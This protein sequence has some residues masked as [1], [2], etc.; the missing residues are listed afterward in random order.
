M[1][2]YQTLFLVS[3]LLI[4]ASNVQAQTF[5]IG[6][7]RDDVIRV[8]GTP[9]AIFTAEF[10]GYEEFRYDFST[11][12]ISLKTKKVLEWSNISENLKVRLNPGSNTS[13]ANYY[14]I[15]SHRDDVLKIQGTPDAIFT[16]EFSGYEEFRYEFS[17][18]KISLRTKKVLEWS[19]ISKNLKVRLEP[20]D[21]NSTKERAQ[22]KEIPP[23]TSTVKVPDY[24]NRQSAPAGY[25]TEG[26]IRNEVLQIQGKPDYLG[27]F[28]DDGY[29]LLW[30][31]K[32]NIKI[33]LGSKRVIDW[34]NN[35]NNLKV[36]HSKET[37][38][39]SNNQIINKSVG[40][41]D[42]IDK[43]QKD[44][45]NKTIQ[46]KKMIKDLYYSE[47]PEKAQ[48][49][50]DDIYKNIIDTY[51]A[52]FELIIKNFYAKENPEKGKRLSDQMIDDIAQVYELGLNEKI[53]FPGN[54][55]SLF[56][57]IK[58]ANPE[59]EEYD[60]DVFKADMHQDE[61]L[62]TVF[63]KF[64]ANNPYLKEYGFY[65][66][67]TDILTEPIT[68]TK[69][70]RDPLTRNS[71]SSNETS[72]TRI[73]TLYENLLK[74]GRVTSQEIGDFQTFCTLTKDPENI[75]KLY[76]NLRNDKFFKIEEIGNEETFL[77]LISQSDKGISQS[78]PSF[79]RQEI[80]QSNI[81]VGQNM[82]ESNELI[83]TFKNNDKILGIPLNKVES[84]L[85]DM[86]NAEE[87]RAFK[88][89]EDKY[90]IPIIKVP[91]FLKDVPNAI[92][93]YN[94]PE[95]NIKLLS[96]ISDLRNLHHYLITEF[97]GF[98]VPFEQFQIDMQD[99]SKLKRLHNN[100]YA[101]DNL[102]VS[103]TEF[104]KSLFSQTANR[105]ETI[106]NENI[107]PQ[108]DISD[109][110]FLPEKIKIG[111]TE[112]ELPMPSFFVRVDN[113]YKEQLEFARLLVPKNA[114]LISYYLGDKDF[115]QLVASGYHNG[116]KYIL[117]E[118]TD[119]LKY[120][121]VE[122][123][124][125][126]R[127]LQSIK[128]DYNAKF[129]TII[130]KGAN[131]AAE[132]ISK[133]FNSDI[134]FK[135]IDAFPLGIYYES[136]NVL[137]TGTLSKLSYSSDGFDSNEKIVACVSSIVRVN[138]K[139][140]FLFLY[141]KYDNQEDLEWIKEINK[142]WM[143]EIE[144][145]QSPTNFFSEFDFSEFKELVFAILFLSF[146]GTSYFVTRRIYKR[147]KKAKPDMKAK[148]ESKDEFVDFNDLLIVENNSDTNEPGRNMPADNPDVSIDEI[149]Q[150]NIQQTSLLN[151]EPPGVEIDQ[152][153]SLKNEPTLSTEEIVVGNVIDTDKMTTTPKDFFKLKWVLYLIASITCFIIFMAYITVTV[154]LGFKHGGG[155]LPMVLLG[156][157]LVWVWK[158]IIGL[159]KNK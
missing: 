144:D 66:F 122:Q 141:K 42:L 70:K 5:T 34:N 155:V 61:H 67:K 14:T 13:G 77:S 21:N 129:D 83:R 127:L 56:Y 78:S 136:K 109:I 45:L 24:S 73:K 97:S 18:V 15:G 51:N 102:V 115:G 28:D 124:E 75:I 137:S 106:Q 39:N 148:T 120:K 147:T 125:F 84:F 54:L 158:K 55:K 49:L 6:S 101:N 10:S 105:I 108:K 133:Y 41:D 81:Y 62:R 114:T 50:T 58:S 35:E 134:D 44:K 92:A 80:L 53:I 22:K 150:V 128:K 33:S 17:T 135:K 4:L 1:K 59:F 27:T 151:D 138:Q 47:N 71:S 76:K 8:Q 91:D 89:G 30:Y 63:E 142:K 104:K 87:V 112:I 119:E 19:N 117:I 154:L 7:S 31:G 79:F 143:K 65:N 132:N 96:C 3:F 146:I 37:N 32:S 118:V 111:D 52:D 157:V 88:V 20:S 93:A 152:S 153:T 139:V 107:S 130:K 98:N 156:S 110:K 116:D 60:F 100:L 159:S 29:E 48:R 74:S 38:A 113:S 149:P 11:V 25:I 95:L 12:K 57:S 126:K 140:F 90:D 85:K 23:S 68:F 82:N 40:T 16:A 36:W 86:P 121:N 69:Y 72:E 46:L 99:E 2:R 43:N 145:K 103:Y 9:D 64:S 26:S 94:Y 123:H 131:E